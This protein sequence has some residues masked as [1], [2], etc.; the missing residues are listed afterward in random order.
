LCAALARV[1]RFSGCIDGS[2]VLVL[3][4]SLP[5]QSQS[6]PAHLS[7]FPALTKRAWIPRSGKRPGLR[8][9][10]GAQARRHPRGVWRAVGRGGSLDPPRSV[11]WRARALRRPPRGGRRLQRLHALA[12]RRASAELR[13]GTS[14]PP[15]PACSKRQTNPKSRKSLPYPTPEL[16]LP[17]RYVQV[18]IC[19]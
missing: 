10:R 9:A 6:K 12:L 11:W 3:I 8:L 5:C 16:G 15:P 13:P 7:P 2:P 14:V 4:H 17:T 19:S 18:R 1:M